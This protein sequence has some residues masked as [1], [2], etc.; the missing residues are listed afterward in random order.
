VNVFVFYGL[1]A[2]LAHL[3]DISMLSTG[4]FNVDISTILSTR[5]VIWLGAPQGLNKLVKVV[6]A[7]PFSSRKSAGAGLTRGLELVG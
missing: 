4:R 5:S 7:R 2:C 1:L 6:K 3:A